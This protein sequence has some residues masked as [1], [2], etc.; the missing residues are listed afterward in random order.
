[1]ENPLQ[2]LRPFMLAICMKKR[3]MISKH[4]WSEF[5]YFRNV[6]RDLHDPSD[7][8]RV[9]F[10]DEFYNVLLFLTHQLKDKEL[11]SYD[12]AF[13]IAN[14]LLIL[15]LDTN[16]YLNGEVESLLYRASIHYSNQTSQLWDIIEHVWG[17]H[18]DALSFGV[19]KLISL[20]QFALIASLPFDGNLFDL[21]RVDLFR[22]LQDHQNEL[23][24]REIKLK[25]YIDNIYHN[26]K[27][28]LL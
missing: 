11:K 24:D 13:C 20:K 18:P 22:K 14:N 2:K 28:P 9:Q 1:M 4:T 3:F 25:S 10:P 5:A 27:P 6:Y 19:I 21:R 15:G 16:S 26:P 17:P 8:F 23:S 7:N 12:A